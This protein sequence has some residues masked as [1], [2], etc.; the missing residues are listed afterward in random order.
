MP[1][2]NTADLKELN[3]Q[4]VKRPHPTPKINT[5]LQKLRLN[6]YNDIRPEHRLLNH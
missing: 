6:P 3:E 1:V 4:I 2:W 5:K